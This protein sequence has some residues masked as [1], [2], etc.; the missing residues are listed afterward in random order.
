MISTKVAKIFLMED[1]PTTTPLA[2]RK[3][4]DKVSWR[5]TLH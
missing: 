2:K 4:E 1:H 5:K 3:R